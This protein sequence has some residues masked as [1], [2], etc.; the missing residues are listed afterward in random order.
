M[1]RAFPANHTV[2]FQ[3]VLYQTTSTLVDLK[4]A[5]LLC[6]PCWTPD[7]VMRIQ[8]YVNQ[9]RRGRPLF[10]FF[11]HNDFDHILGAGAFPDAHVIAS[12]AF[13]RTQDSARILK[14]IHQFDQMY[15]WTRSY[16]IVYPKA[17]TVIR[18]NGQQMI[19][20]N[21]TCTF[22]LSPGH[23]S[24]GLFVYIESPGVFLAG[25]YLSD[26]EVPFIEET[27]YDAYVQTIHLAKAIIEQ[28]PVRLLVPGHGSPTANQKEMMRRVT[29]AAEYLQRITKN[30]PTL[31]QDLAEQFCFFSGMKEAHQDNLRIALLKE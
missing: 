18:K 28:S 26:V 23:T 30:D 29:F 21:S 12:E 10:I 7:E 5:L 6:D 4:D 25:D 2:V 17:D 1:M 13:G 3:S 24:D 11:T 14:Q 20:G 8:A 27:G 22:Y 31:E 15:Y 16:P 9:I 19:I